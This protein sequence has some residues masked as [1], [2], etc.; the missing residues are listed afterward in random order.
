M[1]FIVGVK[2]TN[3]GFGIMFHRY[4]NGSLVQDSFDVSLAR[5]V[6]ANLP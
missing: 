4:N 6:R 2:K 1:N 5:T 3:G